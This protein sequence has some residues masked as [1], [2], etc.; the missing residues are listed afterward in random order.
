MSDTLTPN[1]KNESY[2]ELDF[3]D[4]LAQPDLAR[5]TFLHHR[6]HVTPNRRVVQCLCLH[7]R[8]RLF[9]VIK[10]DVV[11][12]LGS[13]EPHVRRELYFSC[14]IAQIRAPYLGL[15]NIL[16]LIVNYP[17]LKR[18]ACVKPSNSDN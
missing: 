14:R 17:A 11:P 8:R 7:T 5:R 18:E 16:S 4:V 9:S 6:N 2:S 1:P 13:L 15:N 3:Q 10:H 12:S